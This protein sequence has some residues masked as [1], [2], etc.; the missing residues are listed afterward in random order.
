[1]KIAFLDTKQ[2]EKDFINQALASKPD[3]QIIFQETDDC[4]IDDTTFDKIAD[5][6]ILSVFIYHKLGEDK[7]SKMPNLKMICT[8]STGFDHI[9]LEYCKS[10]GI[11]VCNV[12]CYGENTVAEY[13]FALLLAISRQ[14]VPLTNKS[15]KADFEYS[16]F[17][18]FDL[19]GKTIGIIGTGKIGMHAVK[20]AK[21]F[22]MKVLAYDVFQQDFMESFLGFEYTS[23]EN[24][25]SQSDVI[26]LHAPYNKHTHHLMNKDTFS[27][28]KKGAVLINTSRG[29]LV[30]NTALSEALDNKT[31][32][33][34][35]LDVIDNETDLLNNKENSEIFK[36]IARP[37]VIFTPHTAFYSK[38]AEERILQTTLD[39]IENLMNG[40][41]IQTGGANRVC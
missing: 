23:L 36:L 11:V 24:L 19:M 27:K 1:M 9:D 6:D 25:L 13:A 7:L 26:S 21:G 20:M 3:T 39:N 14:I 10:K 18:G 5:V 31:I 28:V 38:E 35:G 32:S 29:G 4:Q 16:Q 12:P 17:R 2:W 30:D 40:K 8:R 41:H 37:N 15:K 34:A 33:F 22:G